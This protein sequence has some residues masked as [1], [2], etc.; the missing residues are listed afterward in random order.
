MSAIS[1]KTILKIDDFIA[2][3]ESDKKNI[4]FWDTCSLLEIIR[5]LYRN[6]NVDDYKILN[7]INALIQSDSIYSIAS[8]L[9][10]KE[11]ND[12]E[13]QVVNFVK[14]SLIKT[15]NFHLN[16]LNVI[17]EINTTTYRSESLDDKNLVNDLIVLA[18]S[19]I[20]KTYFLETTEIA[21]KSLERV[22]FKRPPANKKNEFKD[23]VVWET[24]LLVSQRIY[25]T[26]KETDEYVKI[27]YTV[28]TEDFIDK[29]RVPK[30]FHGT[31]LTE[32][33]MVD[34]IC[35]QNL[36]EIKSSPLI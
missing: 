1:Q 17:N 35:C 24:M 33:S 10:I 20:S 31:L 22:T 8:E 25:V 19:I 36:K 16:S 28:N 34:L 12:N 4:I 11:W 7:E 2:I 26:K 23:C 30:I 3:Y 27:F 18:E 32:A 29:S 15:G 14:D 5:F 13:E 6:G 21:Q 9:T